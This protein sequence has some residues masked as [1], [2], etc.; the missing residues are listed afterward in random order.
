MER[1]GFIIEELSDFSNDNE[2]GNRSNA[3]RPDE[4]ESADSDR[5]EPG[6]QP[7][8]DAAMINSFKNLNCTAN[9]SSD[10]GVSEDED[11]RMIR[12]SRARRRLRRMNAGVIG[13]RTMSERGDSDSESFQH[14]LHPDQVGSSARRLRRRVGIR[15]NLMFQDPLLRL[16]KMNEPP[17]EH[18][19][20]DVLAQE[21]P[22]FAFTSNS[23]EASTLD[24][25]RVAPSSLES[26]EGNDR[27]S[28]EEESLHASSSFGMAPELSQQIRDNAKHDDDEDDIRSDRD[29]C[30]DDTVSVQSYADSVFDAGSVGSSASSVYS[31]TQ[32][33]VGEYVDFLVRDTGL[34]KLFTRSMLP[35]VLG[36][37]RFRRN[38][39]RI[40]QSYARDLKR[41]QSIWNEPKTP[42]RT[43]GLAFISRRSITMKTASIIASRYMEKA[44]RTP[45]RPARTGD[46]NAE[47]LDGD[48]TSSGDESPV[49]ESVHTFVISELGQYFR[50]GAPFQRMKRNLRNLVIPST[51]LSRVKASTEHILDLVLGDDYLRFLLFKA[52]SDPLAPLRDNQFDPERGIRYFGSRLKAEA[53]SPDQFRMAGFLET[54]G[55]YIGTR[56]VQRMEGMG[57]GAILERS[58]VSPPA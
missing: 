44:P 48:E 35:T 33:L 56:A 5:G 21:L 49:N 53:N 32:A 39:S 45:F 27:V 37:E 28:A 43:Q 3:I 9:S 15:Q 58:P 36:P 10:S 26:T 20:D 47:I 50:E 11:A 46:Q 25:S 12:M 23:P 1:S 14:K 54:Y 51:L 18:L 38:Y 16:E 2:G 13:K 34:E 41:Q 6:V 22:F 24:G 19:E 8:I 29:S 17:I 55:G 57:M 7:E 31:D 42:L 30:A 40:L 52:L 4:I